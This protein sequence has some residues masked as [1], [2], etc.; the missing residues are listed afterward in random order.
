M[1]TRIGAPCAAGAVADEFVTAWRAY[2]AIAAVAFLASAPRVCW[3][4]TSVYATAAMPPSAQCW[5]ATLVCAEAASCSAPP[6]TPSLTTGAALGV[7]ACSPVPA[8]VGA[9][10]GPPPRAILATT[11]A[12]GAGWQRV[13]RLSRC[14]SACRRDGVALAG[15][16]DRSGCRAASDRNRFAPLAAVATLDSVAQCVRGAE[17]SAQHRERHIPLVGTRGCQEEVGPPPRPDA[18]TVRGDVITSHCAIV[19]AASAPA[20]TPHRPRGRFG[21]VGGGK[22]RAG[23]TAQCLGPSASQVGNRGAREGRGRPVAPRPDAATVQD[24][25]TVNGAILEAAPEGLELTGQLGLGHGAAA[26][27][28]PAGSSSDPS[29][30]RSSHEVSCLQ[31]KV[32]SVLAHVDEVLASSISAAARHRSRGSSGAGWREHRDPSCRSAKRLQ[33]PN[34]GSGGGLGASALPVAMDAG[35]GV[36]YCAVPTDSP[37][38]GFG[39]GLGA[40]VLPV[41]TD[42]GQG[43]PHRAVPTE[44]R[45]SGTSQG[46]LLAAAGE[47]MKMLTPSTLRS[48]EHMNI[49][50]PSTLRSGRLGDGAVRVD[51]VLLQIDALE[52]ASVAFDAEKAR[53]EIDLRR[54]TARVTAE[55]LRQGR[56]AVLADD[57]KRGIAFNIRDFLSVAAQRCSG[58]LIQLLA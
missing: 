17:R 40:S 35:Q 19:V 56:F 10:A 3:C 32:V 45:P 49:F 7:G 12:V 36:P 33:S 4:G 9:D 29:L 51:V 30:W 54:L 39:G 6:S 42:A 1:A 21:G 55:V 48:G 58:A 53:G 8:A 23:G 18:A 27:R 46:S 15:P 52:Q 16:R 20:P 38:D 44:S 5:A 26:A 22:S 2:E 28:D 31:S 13:G 34:G 25:V 43:V 57:L 24:H 11:P 41:D 37:N 50:T 14:G 47:Q